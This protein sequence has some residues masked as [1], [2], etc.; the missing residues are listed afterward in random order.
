MTVELKKKKKK[1]N[2]LFPPG[3][4]Q[5]CNEVRMNRS[6]QPFNAWNNYSLKIIV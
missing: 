2:P 5:T 6:M 4:C 1:N 3:L